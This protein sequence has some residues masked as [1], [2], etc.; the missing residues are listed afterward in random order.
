MAGIKQ[1]IVD[2]MNLLQAIMVV[3]QDGSTVNL[4]TRIWNNQVQYEKD[5]KLEAFPKPA[6]FVEVISPVAYHQLGGGFTAA[7]L[8]FNIHI[9]HEYY[10]TDVTMEQDLEIF[11]LRDKIIAA[12]SAAQLSG[13][14]P[15]QFTAEQQEYDH[16]NLYHYIVSFV[17]HFINTTTSP[18]PPDG[19][20]YIESTPPA[21]VNLTVTKADVPVNEPQTRNYN[22]PK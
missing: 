21:N 3:N 4:F 2:L 10:N 6:A 16:D 8:G 7:D 11:D 18:Y 13:C 20:K 5:G 12:L 22:I 17:C 19:N 14:G 1:P 9:A 15:L